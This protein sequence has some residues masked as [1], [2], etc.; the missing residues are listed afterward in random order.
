[1]SWLKVLVYSNGKKQVGYISKASARGSKVRETKSDR[2]KSTLYKD[3]IGVGIHGA[4]AYTQQGEREFDDGDGSTTKIKTLSGTSV[5]FGIFADFPLSKNF[6]IRAGLAFREN[7]MTGEQAI[8]GEDYQTVE[9]SQSFLSLSGLVKYYPSIDGS[10]WFGGGAELASG[11]S[12]ELKYADSEDVPVDDDD[13]PFFMFL[14]VGTGYDM[15]I[16]GNFFL[17]PDFRVGV[18]I[19]TSPAI[20]LVEGNLN[21]A[22]RF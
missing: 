13:L 15:N 2:S 20:Y 4:F 18:V 9:L 1:G 8:S 14:N 6:S 5:F 10:F 16:A 12:V 22:Y 19:N 7:N 3:G 17:I 21:V 11:Q